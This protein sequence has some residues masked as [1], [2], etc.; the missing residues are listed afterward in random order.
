MMDAELKSLRQRLHQFVEKNP[1]A[2]GMQK[3]AAGIK[4]F[5]N[6][7][8]IKSIVSF[9]SSIGEGWAP[10]SEKPTTWN[11]VRGV[12]TVLDSLADEW[13]VWGHDYFNEDDEAWCEPFPRAFNA[14]VIDV[15]GRYP[16]QVI[17]TNDEDVF[18]HMHDV[19]G[20][21]VGYQ[22]DVRSEIPGNIY[23]QY[24]KV[25]EVQEIIRKRLWAR[26]NARSL[27][28]TR[29][30][31]LDHT[32]G[33]SGRSDWVRFEEDLVVKPLPSERASD[34][35]SYLKKCIDAGVNRSVMLYGPPGT[36]KSTMARMIVDTLNLTSFRI[37]VEDVSGGINLNSVLF[38]AV[39]IFKPDAII[40]DD[41]DRASGQEALMEMLERFH[42]DIKLVIATVNRRY[43]LDE[44]LL[45]PGR[46]D[47]LQLVKKLDD[48]V[49]KKVLGEHTKSFDLVKDWP[50]VFIEEFV[51]RCRFMTE[52]EAADSIEELAARVDRLHVFDDDEGDQWTRVHKKMLG[53]DV[54]VAEDACE[55]PS[56]NYRK[57]NARARL[58]MRSRPRYRNRLGRKLRRD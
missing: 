16:V 27:V 13:A 29:G 46:F 43:D 22:L 34:Y 24:D 18:I 52:E 42:A 55:A 4:N 7:P 1:T 23:V 48:N 41:F 20:A 6:D 10:F 3:S 45:R 9:G 12:V 2:R 56:L 40:L 58:K 38:E 33:N 17:R 39:K 32:S 35:S 28:M 8:L 49:I 15:L 57:H 19:D 14:A 21:R 30:M 11:A 47:E 44:A 53:M 5:F 51:K 26:Y 36:G 31:Q 37:R 25:V 54:G 50:I